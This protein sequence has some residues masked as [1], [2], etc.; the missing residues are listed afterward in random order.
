MLPTRL[1]FNK[2]FRGE[3]GAANIGVVNKQKRCLFYRG[4]QIQSVKY[5]AQMAASV[6]TGWI[7][8][9]TLLKSFWRVTF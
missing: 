5:L 6:H 2:M 7:L 1:I 8:P 4:T 3:V 9:I